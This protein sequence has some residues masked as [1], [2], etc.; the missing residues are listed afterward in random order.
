M[1]SA[2]Y[3]PIKTLVF[4]TFIMTDQWVSAVNYTITQDAHFN[5]ESTSGV[6]QNLTDTVFLQLPATNF[7]I[8]SLP[9]DQHGL[10]RSDSIG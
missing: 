6:F 3:Q 9:K 4:T 7:T 8:I 5:G 2:C 1:L 10:Y